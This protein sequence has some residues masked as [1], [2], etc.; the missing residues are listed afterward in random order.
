MQAESIGIA[1][2]VR[3]VITNADGTIKKDTGYQKNLILNQGLDF[4]AGG[5]G[6]NINTSCAIGSGN[7]TPVV[8]QTS[9]DSFVSLVNGNEKTFSRGYEDKGDGLYRLWEQKK[10]R[11]TSLGNVNISE[12]G[13][14]SRGTT[15]SDYYLT[16]RALIKDSFGTPTV[17]SVKTGETLDIYY[18]IHKVI[19]TA[20]IVHD[21]NIIDGNGLVA[22]YKATVRPAEVGQE[23]YKDKITANAITD[24]GSVDTLGYGSLS[25]ITAYPAESY[26][27]QQIDI[28]FTEYVIGSFSITR[29]IDYGLSDA[30]FNIKN[31]LIR[32]SLG[33][34][35]ILFEKVGDNTGIDKT[36]QKIM[37]IPF[38]LNWGRYEGAL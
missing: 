5:K 13:L 17:V 32:T 23:S 30:N 36:Y 20:D 26:R 33:V 10:Y 22:A 37:T 38:Q 11:F 7:S 19:N 8:T 25:Q 28:K 12:V 18:K 16:T 31:A 3:C 27:A 2:E 15:S 6:A 4:F 35:Q 14:V 21:I 1:G 9:L 34:W 24:T 29:Y